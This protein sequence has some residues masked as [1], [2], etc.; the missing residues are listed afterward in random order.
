M[1]KIVLFLFAVVLV[2]SY[3]S[4]SKKRSGKPRVLVFSKTADFRHSSIPNGIAAFKK[5][6]E[7]NGF[8]V[9][10]TE[11]ANYFNDDFRNF[12]RALNKYEV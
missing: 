2:I 5:L 1:K 3:S 4:C 9:D 6:G 12:I 8:D 10:A 7:E 11:D